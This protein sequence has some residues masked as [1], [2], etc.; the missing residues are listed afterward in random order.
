VTDEH[1]HHHDTPPSASGYLEAYGARAT[2]RP[3]RA[4]PEP[5]SL[6][7]SFL[8]ALA[9]ECVAAGATVIGHIKCLLHLSEGALACN[10]TSVRG[11]ATC[12][13][14]GATAPPLWAAGQEARLD[15][16]VLVYGL[17]AQTIDG[18]VRAALAR[19]FDPAGIAWVLEATAAEGHSAC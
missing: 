5:E 8:E 11:G 12:S 3:D 4:A 16:A 2:L 6:L 18:L 15:L 14:R 9:A 1:A 13:A 10:L 19:S 7:V 17:S